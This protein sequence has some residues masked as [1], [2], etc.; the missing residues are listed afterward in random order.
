MRPG[1][2]PPPPGAPRPAAPGPRP[3]P[4][5][6][7]PPGPLRP[8]AAPPRHSAPPPRA[9]RPAPRPNPY[10]PLPRPRAQGGPSAPSSA[11]PRRRHKA[12]ARWQVVAMAAAAVV[13]IAAVA[14]GLWMRGEAGG[15][16]LDVRQAEAGVA[17]ILSDPVYGYGAN[18]VAAVAC[19]NGK[20][21]RVEVGSTFMCAVDINGTVRQV[22]V[23]FTD[24]DGTYAVDG[25]R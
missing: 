9:T 11:P 20:N 21:P 13:V 12:P 6:G 8:P 16:R 1:G 10:A 24:D 14:V 23:E 4:P 19:N 17:E 18:D 15:P 2:A 7:P 22:V 3:G 5:P 25:P